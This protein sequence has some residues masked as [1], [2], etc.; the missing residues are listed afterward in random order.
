MMRRDRLRILVS[1]LIAADPGQGGATWGTLQYLLGL[2][3][4][5]HDV[6]LVEPVDSLT[7]ERAAYFSNVMAAF[8]L[9]QRSAMLATESRET[10]GVAY[11][12]L[13]RHLSPADLLINISGML[14]DEGLVSRIPTRVYLDIDPAFNQLWQEAHGI[15]MR[16][17]GHTHHVTIGPGIGQPDCSI[18][19]CGLNWL[20]TTQLV[21]LEQWPSMGADTIRYHGLTT[22]GNW[23]GYGGAEYQGKFYG[24]K[25]HSFREFF[26]V[27]TM[28]DEPF[29]VAIGIHPDEKEDLRAFH[30]NNWQ[31]LDPAVVAATPHQYREFVQASKA[32]LGIAK[33]G[34]VLSDCGWFSD[35]SICYLA[36]GRPVLA[37]DTGYHRYL[38]TGRGLL[39]FATTDEL[40]A[41]VQAINDD[42]PAHAQAAREIAEEYFDSDKVLGSLLGLVGVGA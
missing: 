20:P 37:Q 13:Q 25:V 22:I 14:Q 18:P 31:L 17:G 32:E 8:G 5:G 6:W 9:D 35:R 15:E 7:P 24:Q 26:E 40:V 34:Y 30:R 29:I 3:R 16:F 41:G 4:L 39:K 33:S 10:V 12:V 21:V 19:T 11:E 23:R 27:P 38:P 36:S 2:Q 42:Y 28:T 1:G